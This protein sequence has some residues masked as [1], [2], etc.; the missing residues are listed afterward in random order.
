MVLSRV[1]IFSIRSKLKDIVNSVLNLVWYNKTRFK[2][3]LLALIVYSVSIAHY[4]APDESSYWLLTVSITDY[5]SL[6]IDQAM[7]TY[8]PWK[9]DSKMGVGYYDG[10]YYSTLPPGLSFIAIPFFLIGKGIWNVLVFFG[11]SM[12]YITITFIPMAMLSS[13][14]AAFTI[15]LFHKLLNELEFSDNSALLTSITLAFG[16]ISWVY[17]KTFYAQSLSMLLNFFG[18]YLVILATKYKKINRFFLAGIVVGIATTV[19][20]SN[21]FLVIPVVIYLAL[22]S[23]RINAFIFFIFGTLPAVSLLLLYNYLCFDNPFITGYYYDLI[24]DYTSISSTFSTNPLFGIY[25]LLFS[26]GRG[27]FVYSPVL[28]LS[29]PGFYYFLK[30]DK[31]EAILFIASFLVILLFYSS[32]TWWHGG[33]SF[34]P[35]F[36]T[37]ILPSIVLPLGKTLEKFSSNKYFW[38]LFYLLLGFS[39]FTQTIGALTSPLAD[40]QEYALPRKIDDLTRNGPDILIYNLIKTTK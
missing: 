7:I 15:T 21:I 36:L 34:G 18:L 4:Y 8:T 22:K 3:F 20:V 30:T 16:T 35:R 5:H 25:G 26:P 33:L 13:I 12:S 19:R 29:I 40:I 28:V 14:S 31:E 24:Y 1:R 32:Y 11:I 2:L 6:Y 37:D 23:Q 17:A 9:L 38:I 39:I 10:H 27:L